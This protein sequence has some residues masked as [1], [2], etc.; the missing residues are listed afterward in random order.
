MEA[1]GMEVKISAVLPIKYFF[2]I[3]T[4]YRSYYKFFKY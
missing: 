2:L 4:Y 3:I 1:L